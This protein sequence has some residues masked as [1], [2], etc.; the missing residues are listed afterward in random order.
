METHTDTLR[1]LPAF[2]HGSAEA[3]RVFKARPV[4]K[5]LQARSVVSSYEEPCDDDISTRYEA[6]MPE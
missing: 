2:G 3:A 5:S 4:P 6:R 1:H